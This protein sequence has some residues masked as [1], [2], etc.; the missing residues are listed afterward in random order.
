MHVIAPELDKITE[1]FIIQDV[2]VIANSGILL[3]HITRE[4]KSF[5][6]DDILSSMLTAV[7]DFVKDSFKTSEEGELDELQYGKLRIIIE[8]GKQVYIAAVIRGQESTQLRPM[9][10]RTLKQIHRRFGRVLE[11]WDGDIAGIKGI[12]HNLNPLINLG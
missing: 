4:K 10:K 5:M 6:D 3:K 2:F 9:M 11:E 8:Y 1:P 12:E 7:K